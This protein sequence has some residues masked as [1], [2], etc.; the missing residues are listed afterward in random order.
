[1]R[2]SI[3]NKNNTS[4]YK[5]E[6]L[7]IIKVL[8]SKCI[9]I[10]NNS[11]NYFN[12]INKYLFNTWNYRGTYLDLY[13]YLDG[14]GITINSK[15]VNL[16]DLLNL[17]EFI[18][19]MQLLIESSK[20]YSKNIIYSVKCRSILFHNIPL[21]LEQYNYEAYNIDDKVYIYKRD[22]LYTDLLETLPDSLSELILMY[23]SINNI[24]IKQKR[25][26]LE[27]IYNYLDKD[28]EVYKKLNSPVYNTIKL[29]INKMG[30]IGNIDKKYRD[31]SNYK[32]KKYYDY[33]F[34]LV[35]Y[36]IKTKDI[37][38]YRDE[39]KNIV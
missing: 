20:Y 6:Y 4:N 36:L 31:L 16:D 22:L 34:E 26:I 24:G 3:F 5:S 32:L 29:V 33:C 39:I 37:I 9:T 14:V 27:K 28:S 18:M 10:N 8:S 23:S 21:L 38:K 7:K 25:L 12:F 30:V 35:I 19:N 2:I 11:Y 1:M 13:E 15:K 17:I